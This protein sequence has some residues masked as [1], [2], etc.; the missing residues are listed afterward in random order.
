MP[1]W[2]ACNMAPAWPW[3]VG[4]RLERGCRSAEGT[5]IWAW[6]MGT[7]VAEVEAAV[8]P[9]AAVVHGDVLLRANRPLAVGG[10]PFSLWAVH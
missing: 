2:R 9:D 8:D 10:D 6:G 5:W 4:Q 3:I 1:S 7:V